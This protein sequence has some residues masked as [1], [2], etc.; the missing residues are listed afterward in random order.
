M[1]TIAV[2]TQY[3]SVNFKIAGDR[4]TVQER[5]RIDQVLASPQR[6]LPEDVIKSAQNKRRG[7]FEGF[8]YETGIQD[9]GLRAGLSLAETPQEEEAR[10]ASAGLTEEDYVRDPR[11]RLALTPTG[12]AKFGVETD[13]N[14]VID[15]RG[16]SSSDLAD[17]A[18]LAPEI[19]GA[20]GGAIAG[21]AAIPVPILGAAIGAGIGGAGGNLLEEGIEAASGVSKQ[22]AGEIAS[23]TLT[24]AAIAA[25]GEGLVGLVARGFG[26]VARGAGPR[27]LTED[28]LR[29]VG[30]SREMG[31]T[32]AAGLAGSNALLARAQATSEQIFRG[33][34]RT[35]RNNQAIVR[36]LENLRTAAGTSD[37]VEL[38]RVLLEASKT[39]NKTVLAAERDAAK[40]VLNSLESTAK[41][42]GMATK[43]NKFIDETLYEAFTNAYRAFDDQ[44]TAKFSKIDEAIKDAVGNAEV[45]PTAGV[46]NTAREN[47]RRFQ[48]SIPSG[49]IGDTVTMLRS[50]AALKPSSSFTQIYNARKSLN[51]F[52]MANPGSNTVQTYGEPLLRQIDAVLNTNNIENA[53]LS[54]GRAFD[55]QGIAK[56]RAAANSFGEA[57]AFY[58]E[59]MRKFEE[60]ANV[61]NLNAIR[62]EIRNGVR[63]NPAGLMDRLVKPNNPDLLRRAE[64]V[65]S[66][67]VVDGLTFK[68]MKR[69]IAGEWLRRAIGNSFS[70]VDPTKFRG[71]KFKDALDRLG[72]TAD[73]LFDYKIGSKVAINEIRNL[74]NQ[75]AATSL[76]KV[77]D[78]VLKAVE[79]AAGPFDMGISVDLLK[80]VAKAQKEAQETRASALIQKLNR[81]GVTEMEAAELIANSGTKPDQINRLMKY[82]A[83]EEQAKQKIRGYYMETVIGDFGDNFLA[84]PSQLK[85]FGK[86]IEKEYNSGKLGA[87]FGNDLAERMNKFGRVLVFNSKSVDGGGLV[88]AN[89]AINPI[90]NLGKLAKYSVLGRLLSS[91]LFYKNL[92]KQYKALTQGASAN[93]RSKVLGQLISQGLSSFVAQSGAQLTESGVNEATNQ[94]RALMATY[95]KQQQ[96]R[97]AQRR[98]ANT[99]VPQVRPGMGSIVPPQPGQRIN[100]QSSIREQAAQNPAVAATLLGGLGSAALLNR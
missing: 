85:A 60:I 89:V 6:F 100:Q 51:D 63:V 99:P 75:M 16:F 2:Q 71:T 78:A 36:E 31:I 64:S 84:D 47:L 8:D 20:V 73:E 53:L 59:G 19:G 61:A 21:Q 18:G 91:D 46:A 48:G 4:P 35:V 77:D 68:D 37:P 57:R 90:Q 12:A 9:A 80:N 39:A 66:G 27:A 86:R 28:Q 56:V 82:F 22:T 44:A 43:Q 7:I 62:N 52:L 54:S 70:D 93:E 88:A 97:E 25:T 38:G 94:A 45:I 92:D 17:L 32:P 10:L 5:L 40:T 23:D 50:L 14:V 69:E 81:T 55:E 15:E 58:K 96:E 67:T 65:L 33:S 41:D 87:V 30:E 34:E 13:K 1:G 11:G 29:I 98:Q 3:G 72:S 79:E 24:E 83:D 26:A 74:A 76:S 49:N 42:L 95:E